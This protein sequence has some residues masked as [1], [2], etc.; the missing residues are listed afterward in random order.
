MIAAHGTASGA[1]LT[2]EPV[3]LSNQKEVTGRSAVHGFVVISSPHYRGAE[4]NRFTPRAAQPLGKFGCVNLYQTLPD[5]ASKDTYFSDTPLVLPLKRALVASPSPARVAEYDK[6]H[7][8][9]LQPTTG[10][11]RTAALSRP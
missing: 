11:L 8:T 9:Q 3:S 10:W 7:G 1:R 5:A 4:S 2:C 6:P